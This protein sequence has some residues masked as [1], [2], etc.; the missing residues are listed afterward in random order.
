MM[1]PVHRPPIPSYG[2]YWIFNG[3]PHK[4]NPEILSLWNAVITEDNWEEIKS[5]KWSVECF[6]FL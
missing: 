6:Q 3:L 2:F 4:I 1:L 5:S